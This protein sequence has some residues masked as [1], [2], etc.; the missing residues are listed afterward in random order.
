MQKRYMTAKNKM[1]KNKWYEPYKI[2]TLFNQSEIER[3]LMSP[4]AAKIILMRVTDNG[5]LSLDREIKDGKFQI[6]TRMW[7]FPSNWKL[8]FLPKIV[9]E[10]VE[11][12]DGT[13]IVLMWLEVSIT[14]LLIDLAIYTCVCFFMKISVWVYAPILW[15]AIVLVTIYWK[16][17][18]KRYGKRLEM[19]LKGF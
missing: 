1:K 13:S 11:T 3:R 10:I 14:D 2:L 19:L 4:I 15:L 7:K 17:A 5:F 6:S 12:E 9:G 16:L 18:R 8:F